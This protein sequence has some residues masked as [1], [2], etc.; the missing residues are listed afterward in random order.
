MPEWWWKTLGLALG[1]ALGMSLAGVIGAAANSVMRPS[2]VSRCGHFCAFSTKQTSS[3]LCVP[4]LP[5]LN[6]SRRVGSA[7]TG[8][9]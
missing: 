7:M 9:A 3:L 1:L 6:C 5:A 8:C 4:M 2:T